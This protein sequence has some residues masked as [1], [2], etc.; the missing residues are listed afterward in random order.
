MSWAF[1]EAGGEA[2]RA[3]RAPR[4]QQVVDGERRPVEAVNQHEQMALEGRDHLVLE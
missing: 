1:A 2:R 3:R 4:Y